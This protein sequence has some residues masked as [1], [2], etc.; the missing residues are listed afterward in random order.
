MK[1]EVI[2]PDYSPES[3]LGIEWDPRCEISVALQGGEI[4]LWANR[5]GLVTLARMF[6]SLTQDGVQDGFHVHLDPACGL[7]DGSV[8]LIIELRD[9]ANRVGPA[10]STS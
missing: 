6:L 3:G 4:L 7:E 8:P 9:Q 2:C 1:F 5:D 10:D